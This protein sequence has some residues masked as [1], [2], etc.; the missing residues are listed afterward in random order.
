MKITST[1]LKTI[2]T[3]V[4]ITAAFGYTHRFGSPIKTVDYYADAKNKGQWLSM[5]KQELAAKRK[6]V[7]F[8]TATWCGPCKQF[9]NSLGDPL[10]TDALN[11][12][13]L[14]MIDGDIDAKKD[15][16][17]EKYKVTGY[18][19]FV[20]VD[21]EGKLLNKTDGGAWDENI[22][23]NMAPVMKTFMK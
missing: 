16:L 14:I 23:V 13:T 18:P 15:K 20:R 22:P 19:T 1:F 3:I 2:C 9:K 10:M 4:L 21:A 8:F 5:V 11:G 12:A 7:L 17:T 6:P